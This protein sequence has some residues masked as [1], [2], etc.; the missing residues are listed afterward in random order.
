MTR[1]VQ[2]SRG[3]CKLVGELHDTLGWQ[4]AG[5]TGMLAKDSGSNR[6]R[7]AGDSLSLTEVAVD[8]CC[9]VCKLVQAVLRNWGE[10]DAGILGGKVDTGTTTALKLG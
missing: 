6:C 3:E 1:K 10:T 5:G 7:I 4:G 9:D 2:G 8:G